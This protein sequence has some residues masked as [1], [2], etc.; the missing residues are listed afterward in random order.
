MRIAKTVI[1]CA[2]ASMIVSSQ[3]AM[4]VTDSRNIKKR[5]GMSY[6]L[7]SGWIPD[8]S[9]K[10]GSEQYTKDGIALE[11]FQAFAYA[12]N[13]KLRSTK[14]LLADSLDFGQKTQAVF[15]ELTGVS[16]P[17]VIASE[18]AIKVDGRQAKRILFKYTVGGLEYSGIVCIIPAEKNVYVLYFTA[19]AQYYFE[20]YSGIIDEVRE[21][22]KITY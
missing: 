10:W 20:K 8:P 13:K 2:I 17:P 11:T 18:E 12:N 16:N 3:W 7:L 1:S 9:R 15:N 4:A 6:I 22:V 5:A 14:V 19:P 21:T